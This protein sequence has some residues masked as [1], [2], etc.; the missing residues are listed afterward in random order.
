MGSAGRGLEAGRFEQYVLSHRPD[1][2]FLMF[3]MNDC[4]AG[5]GGLDAF[6]QLVIDSDETYHASLSMFGL[7]QQVRRNPA[8]FR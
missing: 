7:G 1:A 5:P 4:G 8:R 6:D 3:G 2:V